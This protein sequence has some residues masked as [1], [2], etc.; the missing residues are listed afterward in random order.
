MHLTSCCSLLVNLLVTP[1]VRPAVKRLVNSKKTR[2][3]WR[4]PCPVCTR[5]SNKPSHMHVLALTVVTGAGPD[6]IDNALP[7]CLSIPDSTLIGS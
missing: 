1:P 4:D 5:T 7:A 3:R 6:V 2:L